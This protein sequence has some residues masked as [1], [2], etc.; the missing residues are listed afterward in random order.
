MIYQ[1]R[2]TSADA[3]NSTNTALGSVMMATQ[4]DVLDVPFASKT[5]ML[6]Y[7]YST[8]A[9]P[10]E[11]IGHMIECEPRQTTV[12]EL[13][14]LT[15]AVPDNAD[16]RL[17]NLGRFTIATTGFQG[18]NVNIGELHVTYQVRLLKPKLYTALGLYNGYSIRQ[19]SSSTEVVYNNASNMG[20]IPNNPA[21]L[22]LNQDTIG[23]SY[24]ANSI[25]FPISQST[26]FFRIE[27]I[28]TGFTAV[29]PIVTSIPGT[30]G[31]T[32]LSQNLLNPTGSQSQFSVVLGIR[33]AGNGRDIPTLTFS[34]TTLPV[35]VAGNFNSVIT[36][37]IQ[38]ASAI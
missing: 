5:E 37:V 25:Q 33:V 35:A 29:T 4:Y 2:S 8:S 16:P 24:G 14:T 31:I 13:F 30:N 15:G 6:N 1:F 38:T 12:S 19:L 18:S 28:W 23:L 32:V 34:G 17:Y 20:I 9:K 7:E 27:V 10:S 3:L 36:R 22:A 11:N 26:L 21:W